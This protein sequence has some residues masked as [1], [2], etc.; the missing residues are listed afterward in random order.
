MVVP[1][2]WDRVVAFGRLADNRQRPLWKGRQVYVEGRLTTRQYQAK[3]GTGTRYRTEIVA[4][5]LRSLG[6]R[7]KESMQRKRKHPTRP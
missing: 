5:Q 2:Q 1:Y 7:T 6:S 4:L 3:G